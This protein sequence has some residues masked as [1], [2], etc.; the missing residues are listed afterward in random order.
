VSEKKVGEKQGIS[1]RRFCTG[2]E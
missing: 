1:D 2:K